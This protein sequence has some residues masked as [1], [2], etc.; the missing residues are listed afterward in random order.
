MNKI[1]EAQ[2]RATLDTQSLCHLVDVSQSTINSLGAL[3]SLCADAADS[4][5]ATTIDG[6]GMAHILNLI[7]SDLEAAL[8]QNQREKAVTE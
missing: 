2:T 7:A 5:G 1:T 3:S 8:P 6:D 4:C